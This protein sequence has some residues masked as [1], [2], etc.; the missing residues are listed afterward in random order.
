MIQS[1]QQQRNPKIK[2]VASVIVHVDEDERQVQRSCWVSRFLEERDNLGAKESV[3]FAFSC[4]AISS[5]GQSRVDS[6]GFLSIFAGIL[7][8][9]L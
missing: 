5:D 4:L 9:F 2:A 6:V 1:I 3:C 7:V 8:A